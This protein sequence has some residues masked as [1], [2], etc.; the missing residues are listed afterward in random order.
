MSDM[1]VD[2]WLRDATAR[3][4]PVIG[5][6]EAQRDARLILRGVTGWSA[7]RLLSERGVA[8]PIDRR[9]QAS[10]MLDRRLAREPLAQILG[11]W[12]FYGRDFAVTRDV[13]TPRADTETLIDLALAEPFSSVIDLGT[14]SGAIV[15]TL[16][17]ERP[18]AQ[19]VAT[20]LSP[21]A[22][23]VAARNASAHGVAGRL[24]LTEADWW[25]G[26]AGRFDLIVS[27]PPYVTAAAYASLAPEITGHEPKSALTPGDDGL[28]AYRQILSGVG[29]HAKPGARVLFEIGADQGAALSCLMIAAGLEKVAIHSDINGKDR[30]AA[31]RVSAN[32]PDPCG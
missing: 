14:G 3:L 30:V 21:A 23:A 19:G 26:V 31:G 1:T 25:S 20:D 7:A 27:N 15:V 11:S 5:L 17:A 2:A 8:L 9:L 22:L 32:A 4:A 12:P 16:L 10:A 29:G 18:G 28:A 24:R 6:Q 13:L